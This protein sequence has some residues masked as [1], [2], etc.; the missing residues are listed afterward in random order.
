MNPTTTTD[1]DTRTPTG[2]GPG[3]AYGEERPS[4]LRSLG[5]AVAMEWTKASS[6]R[7]TWW[8]VGLALVAMAVFAGLMGVTK[9][10]EVTDNP[11]AAGGISYITLVS[12]GVFYLVQF[13]VVT[14]A[15]LTAT[16]EFSGRGASSTLL[17]VPR[18]GRVLAARS[19][20]AAGFG[21]AIGAATT[22][23]G[24]GVLR[25]VIGDLAPVDAGAA[26]RTVLASGVC[27]ALFA[28]LFTG[29]GTALRSTAGTIAIGFLLLLGLPMVMQLSG[30]QVVNDL[31]AVLPGPAGIEFYAFGDVGLYTAP[32]D[33]PVNLA[34]VLGWTAAAVIVGAAEFR[35]RDA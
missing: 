1:T 23:L 12:Q 13:A 25:L 33:G 34:T 29:V 7:T 30:L 19:L 22:A 9:A 26:V 28:V 2:A 14:L 8:C 6:L 21:F 35:L 4:A 10:Q 11:D 15:A 16:G 24:V 5:R 20:V 3:A 17:A 31:S 18:R 27:M 32:V